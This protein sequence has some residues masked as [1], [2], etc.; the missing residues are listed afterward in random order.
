MNAWDRETALS[1]NSTN[2]GT[3]GKRSALHALA[4]SDKEQSRGRSLWLIRG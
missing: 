2:A 1:F 4:G 3:D